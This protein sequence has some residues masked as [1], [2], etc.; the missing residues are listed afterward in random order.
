MLLVNILTGFFLNPRHL[1]F[2]PHP[3]IKVLLRQNL[4][5]APKIHHNLFQFFSHLHDFICP[6]KWNPHEI[7]TSKSAGAQEVRAAVGEAE[8]AEPGALGRAEEVQRHLQ[9][10]GDGS[11]WKVD[12]PKRQ[13]RP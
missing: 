11:C 3:R 5:V 4:K 12:A 6:F 7:R 2:R 9:D 1:K 13:R 8:E 10:S